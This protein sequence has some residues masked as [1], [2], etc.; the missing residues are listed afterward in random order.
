MEEKNKY[1]LYI[2]ESC[3]LQYDNSEVLCV[4]G[5]VVPKRKISEYKD[6]I[7]SVKKK[8]GILQELKW[9][10]IS[11][12]HIDLY[13][14]LISFFFSSELAFRGILIKNKSNISAQTLN[15]KEYNDFYFSV[16]EKLIRYSV[17]HNG[18][19]DNDFKVYLDLKDSHG[20]SKLHA[21]ESVLYQGLT[22]GNEVSHLQNIRSHESVFIQ[23]AD[24]FIGA[25]AYKARKLNGSKAKLQVVNFIETLSGYDIDEGTEPGDIKFSI[26][27]FQPKKRNG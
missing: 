27:D 8:Y 22:N 2:D 11:A 7:K 14:E 26:Y 1:N 16:V 4:G 10:T 25:I 21:I 20:A 15:R 13:K 3:H 19:K 24:I 6:F 5:I 9:N 17:Q 23:L 12:T 18:G